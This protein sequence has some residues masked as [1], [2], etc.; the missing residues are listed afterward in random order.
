MMLVMRLYASYNRCKVLL[1]IA[2]SLQTAMFVL[3]M[4][5]V[6]LVSTTKKRK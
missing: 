4:V 3:N 5:L 2:I 6:G 1:G